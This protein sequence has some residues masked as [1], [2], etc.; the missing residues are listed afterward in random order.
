[1]D[2]DPTEQIFYY[3]HPSWRSMLLFYVKGV[4]IGVIAG[5][6]AGGIT[7][8][9]GDSVD[10]AV[11]VLVVVVIFAITLLVGFLRRLGTVY[12]I[13]SKRLTIKRGLIRRDLQETRIDR[14]QNVNY[15]QSVFERMLMIGT[16]DFDTAGSSEYD[17]KFYGVANP[18]GI[19]RTVD[20]A[21]GELQAKSG[22]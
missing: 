10:V 12:S 6:I 11:V 7:R 17:F 1:V 20:R 16:V 9:S 15:K 18:H 13:G 4:I 8:A 2:K 14:V 3:G 22:P 5:A 21:L 19:V